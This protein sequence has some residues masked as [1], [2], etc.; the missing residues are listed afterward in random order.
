MQ[1][2][3]SRLIIT[4]DSHYWPGYS[5]DHFVGRCEIGDGTAA[6]RGM[7][8]DGLAVGR[9]FGETGIQRYPSLEEEIAEA[10][11]ELDEHVA[12]APRTLVHHRR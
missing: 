12:H 8:E 5:G 10:F 1:R 11:R 4:T 6:V 3:C 9:G 7:Q 2:N